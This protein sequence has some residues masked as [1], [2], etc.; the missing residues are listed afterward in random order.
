MKG[1]GAPANARHGAWK[2]SLGAEVDRH[3]RDLLKRGQSAERV[4]E[5][6]GVATG[7]VEALVRD[8][9]GEDDA[10]PR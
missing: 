5:L 1:A 10:P 6:V 3:I 8:E 7:Y 2:L 9:R 4:A